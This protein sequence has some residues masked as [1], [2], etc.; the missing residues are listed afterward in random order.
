MNHP[1]PSPHEGNLLYLY[2][3]E[4][5]FLA[6]LPPC[7]GNS[8]SIT[9]TVFQTCYKTTAKVPRDVN[10]AVDL[11]KRAGKN[12]ILTVARSEDEGGGQFS[13]W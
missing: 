12:L 5:D 13:R 9:S 10:D 7:N 3:Q 11:I 6:F 2:M 1:Q 8:L 4:S